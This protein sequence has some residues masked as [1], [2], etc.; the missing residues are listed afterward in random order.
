M[1]I[2][3]A[4]PHHHHN[5]SVICVKDDITETECL[6]YHH[7]QEEHHHASDHSC[8]AECIT[9]FTSYTP[10]AKAIEVQPQYPYPIIL[11][12]QPIFRLLMEPEENTFQRD[13]VYIESLHGTFITRAAGL[14]APPYL[15][16]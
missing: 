6:C 3:S 13:Y 4:I 15:L 12:T 2:A 7:D 11:F 5:K 8:T 1:V 14:R 16:S 10:T 9:N